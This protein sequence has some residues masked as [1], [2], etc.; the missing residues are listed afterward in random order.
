M[1]EK[2]PEVDRL[3][4]QEAKPP[5]LSHETAMKVLALHILNT[6]AMRRLDVIDSQK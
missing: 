6:T 5:M 2:R 3:A 4:T 1:F